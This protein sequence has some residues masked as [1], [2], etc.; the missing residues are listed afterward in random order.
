[1]KLN[2]CPINLYEEALKL[3][4]NE[5]LIEAKSRK[6]KDDEFESKDKAT[7]S[8]LA[9]K[10]E[11]AKETCEEEVSKAAPSAGMTKKE[12]S[13]VV[14]KAK[15]GKDLGNPA[16]DLKKSKKLQRNLVQRIQRQ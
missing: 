15:A 14:K 11:K 7:A 1:M 8:R 3:A 9:K 5:K 6:E 12:K 16:K 4:L 13:A 10:K 2:S